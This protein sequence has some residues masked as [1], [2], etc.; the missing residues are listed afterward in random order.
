MK[1]PDDFNLAGPVR[2]SGNRTEGEVS[3]IGFSQWKTN[4]GVTASSL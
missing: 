2:G 4:T 1:G 3:P